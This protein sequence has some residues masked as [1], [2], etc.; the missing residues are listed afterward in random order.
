MKKLFFINKQI[1]KMLYK[2][3]KVLIINCTYKTN[4]YKMFLLTIIEYIVIN[5]T[6]IINIVFLIKKIVNY[7]DWILNYLK[8]L[9]VS[10]KLADFHVIITN[11]D[12]ILLE[13]IDVQ[14]F[15][16]TKHILYLWYV[17]RNVIKNCKIFFSIKKNWETFLIDWHAIIYAFNKTKFETIWRTLIIRW[18]NIN[19]ENIFYIYTMWLM[20]WYI[21]LCKCKIN[22]IMHFNIIIISR[23]ENIY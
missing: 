5:F 13:I 6:F 4:K 11:W 1:I 14:Y 16:K 2:N 15:V 18:Y 8:T 23:A 3:F 17:H 22:K 20:F 21:K 10:L 12:L 9:Y 7:Y 19:F